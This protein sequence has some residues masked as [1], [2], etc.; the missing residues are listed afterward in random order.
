MKLK[1]TLWALAFACAAVSCSD[2]LDESGKGE[3][4]NGTNGET[5]Y[6][7]V[8]VNPGIIT[9]A[10]DVNPDGGEEGDTP[11]GETGDSK[12]YQ[13]SDVT[14]ILYK[15]AE[16]VNDYKF[17]S[18][19]TIVAAGYAKT[20]AMGA[21]DDS[22]HDKATTVQVTVAENN[23]SFDGNTYGVITV[24]NWGSEALK[25]AVLNNGSPI[26]AT[27]LANYLSE[28]AIT[29]EGKFIMS[30]HKDEGETVTLVA[31]ATEGNAPN[32]NVHVERLAAKIR[33]N[34]A[35]ASKA[36]NFIYPIGANAATAKVRLDQV[37]VVNQLTSGSYL[38]KR[39]TPQNGSTK[40]VIPTVTTDD[41][42][43]DELAT[44]GAEVD[45]QDGLNYVI[46]P[47][48]RR[49]KN[50]ANNPEWKTNIVAET[51]AAGK[52]YPDAK[53][54]TTLSYTNSF[55]K[56]STEAAGG[57]DAYAD[58]ATLW[59]SFSGA[60][61][62]SQETAITGQ[63]HLC[64]TM[65]NTTSG[66]N[67]LNGY[68]TGAVFKATYLPAKWSATTIETVDGQNKDVVKPV[69]VDYN[70]ENT[71]GTGYDAIDHET[72]G[73]DFYVYGG[74]IYKD[75]EAI[76]NVSVWSVQESL[77][78]VENAKIYD[79]SDFSEE[80]IVDIKMADFKNSLLFDDNANDPFGYLANLRTIVKAAETTAGATG[81]GEAKFDKSAAISS[82]LTSDDNKEAVYAEVDFFDDGVC[83]YP[84]WIRHANNNKTTE[85]GIMEFGIVR[86]NIYDMTVTGISGLG[87][88]GMAKPNPGDPDEK[89]EY[90]FNVMINVKNW[91]VR[92]NGDIIL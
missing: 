50:T 51:E 44:T 38:L 23:E 5:T 30:S 20:G 85:M 86:N 80:K 65:E 37:A 55:A 59:A 32:A 82:Y 43:A 28:K 84:Y 27:N 87:L 89:K 78:G 42:L 6:M 24:T 70:G 29:D 17:T 40:D 4:G 10:D 58:Y 3:N 1:S 72:T 12:E 79:Y 36:T 77:E 62:L 54:A 11:N 81:L 19:S 33:I 13:V 39:V 73:L 35:D 67:S 92:K 41:W 2:E 46:D 56:K 60:T 71:T 74:N 26:S 14:V 25:T 47:W 21:G 18:T 91:V 68:S 69:D 34:P 48:T 75:M 8:T 9:R 15:Q 83:Y 57:Y 66:I 63:T 45:I 90:R 61:T 52:L 76:F 16:G 22:W 31:N 7:K 64:Y 88:S 53:A 49:K